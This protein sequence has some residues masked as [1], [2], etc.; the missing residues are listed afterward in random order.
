MM[1]AGALLLPPGL[2]AVA[3]TDNARTAAAAVTTTVP[4]GVSQPSGTVKN[5]KKTN[6]FGP[7]IT[8]PSQADSKKFGPGVTRPKDNITGIGI[9]TWRL[10]LVVIVL[11]GML[12]GMFYVLRK[13]GRGILPG[14]GA[15]I[16]KI[17]A[18]VQ[19]DA[20][21]SV[22]VLRIYDEEYV[23]GAGAEGVRL[24]SKLMPIDGIESEQAEENHHEVSEAE[25][26]EGNENINRAAAKIE[27][28]F[29][30][31]FK[32]MIEHEDVK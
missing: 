13:Y 18:K 16:I 32:K 8:D 7:G 31:R 20:K 23:V 21:N 6:A 28:D 10:W 30:S 27:Q 12:G 11:I 25:T 1:L 22:S 2:M 4:A 19:L 29:S 9:E 14:G 15:E 24:L 17:K 3:D 5:V 26:E